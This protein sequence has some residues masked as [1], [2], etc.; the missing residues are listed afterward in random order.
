[1]HLEKLP[2]GVNRWSL[3]AAP[4]LF[5]LSGLVVPALKNGDAAQV[6][7]ISAHPDA[8]YAFTIVSLL[9]S[10]LLVPAALALMHATGARSTASVLGAGLLCVGGL[11]ALADSATQ[12]VYWQMGSRS[13]DPAQMAALLHRYE[14]APGASVIFFVG[15]IALV[16]G[17]VLL[18]LALTRTRVAPLWAAVLIPV[19]MVANLA[20]FV[21]SSK[22]LLIVSSVVLLAGMGR[23][24]LTSRPFSRAPEPSVSV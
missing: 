17:T 1:M 3:V 8:W 21:G 7:M 9:G 12:L 24:A 15:A 23:I 2:A 18:A 13:A 14:N 6:A 22:V 16:V 4:S 20:A 19:G 11:V 5:A 10:A